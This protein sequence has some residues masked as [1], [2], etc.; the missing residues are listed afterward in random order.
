VLPVI[1]YL[2]ELYKWFPAQLATTQIPYITLTKHCNALVQHILDSKRINLPASVRDPRNFIFPKTWDH[3]GPT[4]S[5]NLVFVHLMQQIL[6]ED[7]E[8]EIA[9]PDI[10]KKGVVILN[11]SD[12]QI[13]GD[14]V[15]GWLENNGLLKAANK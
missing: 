10:R 12:L 9:E 8:R 7:K 6:W 5:Y 15:N 2:S 1:P 3:S 4:N 13:A 14:L 11:K